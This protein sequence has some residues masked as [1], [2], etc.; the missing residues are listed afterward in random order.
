MMSKFL[1]KQE[2]CDSMN[3]SVDTLDRLIRRGDLRAYRV[4]R[5][6][7]ISESD[8]ESYLEGTRWELRSP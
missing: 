8:L 5:R 1:T 7:R 4:A 6:I 2:V 3:V